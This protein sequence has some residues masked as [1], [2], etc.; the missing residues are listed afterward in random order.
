MSSKYS[1]YLKYKSKYLALKN[2]ISSK[3]GGTNLYDLDFLPLIKKWCGDI[4]SESASQMISKIID[5]SNKFISDFE[6]DHFIKWLDE[7]IVYLI[8]DIQKVRFGQDIRSMDL[9]D[10]EDWKKWTI[11]GIISRD[12]LRFLWIDRTNHSEYLIE[13]MSYLGLCAKIPDRINESFFL[14]VP[15]HVTIIAHNFNYAW[16]PSINLEYLSGMQIDKLVYST[17]QFSCKLDYIFE[18][19]ITN[20]LNK[21]SREYDHSNFPTIY[22]FQADIQIAGSR[23]ILYVN[24]KDRNIQYFICGT[25]LDK[26]KI[27]KLISDELDLILP[28]YGLSSKT[29]TFGD[30]EKFR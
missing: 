19:I 29:Y 2:S 18:T 14:I 10:G 17:I 20:L 28:R 30:F 5:V 1:K 13:I 21:Y 12:L 25:D 27:K 16:L 9:N 22:N 24:W 4:T 26:S 11:N 7:S 6:I 8:R 3:I 23:T 15:L